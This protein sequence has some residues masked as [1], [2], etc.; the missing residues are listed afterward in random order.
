MRA[1]AFYIYKLKKVI[2]ISQNKNLTFVAFKL[3]E[4]YI[5]FFNDN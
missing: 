2:M 1:Y 3:I 5:K 4:S